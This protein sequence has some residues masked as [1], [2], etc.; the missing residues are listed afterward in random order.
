MNRSVAFRTFVIFTTITAFA[1]DHR[2]FVPGCHRRGDRSSSAVRW[3]RSCCFAAR[4][5]RGAPS[6][7]PF[8]CVRG[9]E[10][11]EIF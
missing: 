10:T 8:A 3:R 4:C 7:F 9:T 6:P 2:I 5:R 11:L 1:S